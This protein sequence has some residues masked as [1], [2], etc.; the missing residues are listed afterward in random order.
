MISIC[1]LYKKTIGSALGIDSFA[2]LNIDGLQNFLL[3]EYSRLICFCPIDNFYRVVLVTIK[4]EVDLSIQTIYT[5]P[6][7]PDVISIHEELISL[8]ALG[9]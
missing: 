3:E 4:P 9:N 2:S 1:D 5:C 8:N 7:R 6:I